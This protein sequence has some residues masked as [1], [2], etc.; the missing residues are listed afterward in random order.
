MRPMSLATVSPATVSP[1]V[2]ESTRTSAGRCHFCSEL[3]V[4]AFSFD[5]ITACDEHVPRAAALLVKRLGTM[6]G[7]A[8]NAA[9]LAGSVHELTTPLYSVTSG[10]GRWEFW[11]AASSN[12]PGG[13]SERVRG[14]GW[15]QWCREDRS[16]AK[17]AR[18]ARKRARR[19][20]R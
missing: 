5:G 16:A 15:E 7:S 10:N 11:G 4:N 19:L 2:T 8:H 9:D 3:V 17:R 6:P 13:P 1:M 14:N 20:G 18:A 12:A